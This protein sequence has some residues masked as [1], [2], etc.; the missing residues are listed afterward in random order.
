MVLREVGPDIPTCVT[1]AIC[2]LDWHRH[3]VIVVFDSAVLSRS[4]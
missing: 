3:G 4:L 1:V 2:G